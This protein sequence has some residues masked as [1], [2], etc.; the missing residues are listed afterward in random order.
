MAFFV[1]QVNTLLFHSVKLDETLILHTFQILFLFWPE[2]LDQFTY[3]ILKAF[4][5]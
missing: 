1:S 3:P 5:Y 2:T 4:I